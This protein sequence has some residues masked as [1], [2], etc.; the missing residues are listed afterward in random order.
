MKMFLLSTL[1]CVV[2]SI[3]RVQANHSLPN[4]IL[5]VTDDQDVVLDSMVSR[6]TDHEGARNNFPFLF[7][8]PMKTVL[9]RIAGKGAT[10]S[11]AFTSSPIC[12]PSRASILSGQYAHNS[13]TFNNSVSGG[14]Y[15]EFWRKHVES[16]TIAAVASSVG[17]RTFFAGKYLNE[18]HGSTVPPRWDE[19]YGLIG[20]SKYQNYSLNENGNI[21]LYPEAYL[22]DVIRDKA[23]EFVDNV[24]ENEPFFMYLAP[25]APHSPYTP[26]QRHSNSFPEVRAKRTPNFNVPSGELDKHWLMTMGS[27]T[28]PA[29]VLQT[30]DKIARKRWQSLM[31]VD[32]MIGHLLDSLEARNMLENTFVIFT[33]DNG[34]HLGQFAQPYDKRQPYETDIR[35]PLVVRGPAVREKVIVNQP[36]LLIDLFPTILQMIGVTPFDYLDGRSFYPNLMQGQRVEDFSEL[37]QDYDRLM[38]VEYWGEFDRKQ[39][40][41]ECR[42]PVRDQVAYCTVDAACRCQD[43]RNNTY[44]CIRHMS[45]DDNYLYCSFRDQQRFVEIFDLSVDPY[46]MNNLIFDMLPAQQADYEV[47]LNNLVNCLGA[48]CKKYDT[49]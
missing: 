26:A 19:F 44:A 14:C 33:S 31:A 2:V 4:V 11:N 15:G 10:F 39:V 16:R 35:V 29:S 32:E 47:K 42:I 43:A 13:A 5:I 25:P 22:T 17:L 30:V 49:M 24:P 41:S 1:F 18:F 28:L 12:C 6:E 38:L 37:D 9:N 27:K 46:E 8:T 34:Y 45:G 23:V 21:V 7:Q 36:T 20:N 40:D 48:Q 3:I